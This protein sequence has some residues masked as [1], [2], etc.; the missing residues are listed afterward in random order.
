MLIRSQGVCE[1][2]HITP[3]NGATIQACRDNVLFEQS[4]TS[5]PSTMPS[6]FL[7]SKNKNKIDNIRGKYIHGEGVYHV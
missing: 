1:V 3:Q 5:Y 2:T 7:L 6:E 4:Y